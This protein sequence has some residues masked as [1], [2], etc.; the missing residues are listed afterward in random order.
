MNTITIPQKVY[1]QLAEKAFRF[2]YLREIMNSSIFAPP[3]IKNTAEIIEIF[4]NTKKYNKEFIICL[5]N[6]MKRSSYFE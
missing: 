5:E 2:E 1:Q 4:K 3:P 6:G